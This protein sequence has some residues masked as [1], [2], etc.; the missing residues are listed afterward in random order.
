MNTTPAPSNL[1]V[2]PG[3]EPTTFDSLARLVPDELQ[4]AYY[5]VLAPSIPVCLSSPGTE[6]AGQTRSMAREQRENAHCF[7]DA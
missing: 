3:G 7:E 4:T 2:M 1:A 6:F 5:R